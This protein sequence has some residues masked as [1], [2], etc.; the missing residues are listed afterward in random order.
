MLTIR[1][2]ETAAE[3]ETARTLFREYEAWFGM[4]LCFQDFEAEVRDL[5]GKYVPPEGRLYLAYLFAEP[6]GC[7]A[8]R[9]LEDG[10]CEMK[11]LYL[12][13]TARGVGAGNQL[14][15]KLIGEARREG[16]T[17]MRLDTFPPKMAKAVQIYRAHGFCEIAPY[18]HNPNG[19]TL[20]MELSL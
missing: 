6:V 15:E 2:A 4:D 3:I 8:M 14:I 10:I 7:I 5:P 16:Y 18:Y 13:E 11:R 19:E 17:K 9:K 12:R 1:Q 20:F